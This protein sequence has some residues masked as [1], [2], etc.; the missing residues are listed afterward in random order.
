[1]LTY[2]D[3]YLENWECDY[4]VDDNFGPADAYLFVLTN[5]SNHIEHDLSPYKNIVALRNKIA[6]RQSVQIAM[7][8]EGLIP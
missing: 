1:L 4:L 5:W 6:E 2:I 7:R 8:D 3:N